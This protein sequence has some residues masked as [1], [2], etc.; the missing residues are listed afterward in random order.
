MK[1]AQQ[2]SPSEAKERF[3]E[4]LS[5]VETGN[6]IEIIRNGVVIA[7]ITHVGAPVSKDVSNLDNSALRQLS[8]GKM[9]RPLT[10]Q[11]RE[12]ARY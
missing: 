2:L 1:T 3:A 12:L 10:E 6:V 5:L 7:H 9:I 8:D 11:L 4:V